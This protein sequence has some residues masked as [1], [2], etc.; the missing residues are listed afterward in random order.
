MTENGFRFQPRGLRKEK[1]FPKLNEPGFSSLKV[2]K[3]KNLL[4]VAFWAYSMF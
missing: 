2:I 1:Y 4:G 3:P